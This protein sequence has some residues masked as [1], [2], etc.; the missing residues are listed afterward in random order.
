MTGLCKRRLSGLRFAYRSA[1]PHTKDSELE[2]D[3]TSGYEVSTGIDGLTRVLIWSI[4]ALLI[5]L[6]VLTSERRSKDSRATDFPVFYGASKIAAHS[7]SDLYVPKV[8]TEVFQQSFP[9]SGGPKAYGYFSYP[10]FVALLLAPA[11]HLSFWAAYR[12]N[13]AISALLYLFGLILLVRRFLRHDRHLATVMI[14]FALAYFPF[15]CDTWTAGQLSVLGFVSIAFAFAELKAGS[16]FRSGLALSLCAYKPPLLLLLLPMLLFR[17]QF[18]VLLGFVTGTSALVAA[19]TVAYGWRI[20]IS[21]AHFLRYSFPHMEHLRP[22]VKYVDL[23]AFFSLLFGP[24]SASLLALLC[25]VAVIPFLVV[26]WWHRYHAYPH[27]VWACTLTW[28]LLLGPYVPIYDTVLIVPIMIV[29][30][31][32]VPL[33]THRLLPFSL[34]MIFV[35]SWISEGLVLLAHLQLLT[36]VVAAFGSLQI[37]VCLRPTPQRAL[38]RLEF[39]RTL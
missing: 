28:G 15:I 31:S 1:M 4:A 13:Q 8:Q 23:T 38:H 26:L 6:V 29:G 33:R 12:V 17:R 25:A 2:V 3:S 32:S 37:W 24:G 22:L 30:A 7:P 36:V 21:Y 11:S 9:I 18:R 5:F 14:P 34:L 19:A 16:L 27:L 39:D 20:W 10:P 35:S